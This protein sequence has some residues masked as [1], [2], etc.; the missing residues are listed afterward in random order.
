[1]RNKKATLGWAGLGNMG[2]PM[3][4]RLLESGYQM[5]VYNRSAE[6]TGT[7]AGLGARVA[8]SPAELGSLVDITFTM[9]ADSA[10]LES[11]AMGSGSILEGANPGSILID[12]ST[13]SPAASARV[14]E[15]AG[16][17]NIRYLRA[18]VSGSTP[19]AAAGTLGIMVSGD[20]SA[21]QEV[22]EILKVLGQ[23]IFYLGES[24][25]ARYMKLAVN[26][27]LGITGQ[28]LGEALAFG[29]KAGLDWHKMLEVIGNS[30]VASPVISYKA[31]T[32][33]KRDFSPMFALKLLDKDF[34]LALSAGKELCVPL[35]VTSLVKQ[36]LT[37]AKATGKSELDFT[38]LVLQAEELSGIGKQEK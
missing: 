6:K 9:V 35:P 7:A 2:Q 12:M 24:E 11:I 32:L 25:E 28:M 30:A 27:M 13:V 5:V 20:R 1:M 29:K 16:E 23:K 4:R 37:S 34:D 36:L 3:S 26:I 21:L 17:K 22:S 38:A 19:A 15:A 14:A 33:S 8:S 31:G 18:P 10:A